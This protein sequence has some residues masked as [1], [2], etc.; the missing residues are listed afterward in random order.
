MIHSVCVHISTD[1]LRTEKQQMDRKIQSN[2]T[3]QE[4]AASSRL[5]YAAW[6]IF[7]LCFYIYAWK[8]VEPYLI[9]HS[10]GG[11]IKDSHFS[12]G[13][14]FFSERCSWPGGPVE[15]MG[16]FLSQLYY[17]NWLGALVITLVS[18]FI[19]IGTKVLIRL[20]SG[21][22]GSV[23]GL[24]PAF[25][26]LAIYS[27][28]DNPMAM[29]LGLLLV[30]W[31]SAV[32][33]ILDFGVRRAQWI[34]FLILFGILYYLTAGLSLLFVISAGFFEVLCKRKLLQGI[35]YIP[36]AVII[37]FVIGVLALAQEALNA[38]FSLTA[39]DW[40]LRLAL[41]DGLEYLM[42]FLYC[43]VIF[44]TPVG[45]LWHKLLSR[46]KRRAAIIGI[47][48]TAV[49]LIVG[50]AGV[51]LSCDQG[52][53]STCRT[54]Y[55]AHHQMWDELLSYISQMP[56]MY[57]TMYHNYCVNRA[58][59]KTG[60]LGDEMF[61][62]PQKPGSLLLTST[63][64]RGK[65][66]E[67]EACRVFMELGLINM[68]EKKACECFENSNSGPVVLENLGLINL[69]KGRS[70]TAQMCFE[71]MSRDLI[72]GWKGKDYLCHLE[73]ETE[74]G[75]VKR[76]RSVMLRR[77]CFF[78]D[79]QGEG[80]LLKLL[81]DNRHNRM[82]FEYLMAHYMLKGKLEKVVNNL[83]R[84][85]DF[86]YQ[87]IPRHYEEA[88]L[89]HNQISGKEVRVPGRRISS[90]SLAGFA[91]FNEALEKF[92][93][94]EQAAKAMFDKFGGSYF[95]YYMFYGTKD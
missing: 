14:L 18:A 28:Y 91:Q 81:E 59:Y 36:V 90:K 56:R 76:L 82:A 43:F 3:A 5:P 2:T 1:S 65:F 30:I 23:M 49:I 71:L 7:F 87:R 20:T 94:K 6:A 50:C 53:K 40:K 4:T 25:C 15:Y 55:M 74:P 89:A 75:D 17:F 27:L 46:F 70:R 93:S 9:Y 34:K 22:S 37:I 39:L 61:F 64:R 88:L 12:T 29:I 72:Y 35:I 42:I 95:Y 41:T 79:A 58:L 33:I 54:V 60:R 57:Y 63:K 24:V 67:L 47:I 80:L 11:I 13:W 31:F 16:R 21:G 69:I 32:Y 62:F 8:I 84:L 77:D 86:G 51:F 73:E 78:A 19:C 85:D 45:Q 26:I 83:T 52:R 38:Y 44:L 48:Q 92:D 66:A 10:L 68:A